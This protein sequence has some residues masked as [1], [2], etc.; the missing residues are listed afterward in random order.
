MSDEFDK[1]AERE[2]LRKKFAEDEQ[3]RS[4]TQRMS[5]LLLQGATMTNDHCD[6]CGDPLFRQNGQTFCPTCADGGAEAAEPPQSEPRQPTDQS[7]AGSASQT[8]AGTETAGAT[9]RSPP[10]LPENAEVVGQVGDQRDG[11]APEQGRP[12]QPPAEHGSPQPPA[13][14]SE[15][16]E[17]RAELRRAVTETARKAS[18]ATDPR[19]AR[20]WLEASKEAAEALSALER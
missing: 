2:K 15:G 20:A 1:E 5:E 18:A 3:K 4:E 19:T 16:D 12:A 17:P 13:R 6:N 7:Q 8:T 11:A 14:G 9:Q 10:Q